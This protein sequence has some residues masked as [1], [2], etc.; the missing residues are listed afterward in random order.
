MAIQPAFSS[1]DRQPLGELGPDAPPDV[2][3]RS[4]L[5]PASIGVRGNLAEDTVIAGAMDIAPGRNTVALFANPYTGG[6]EEMLYID[7]QATLRWAR[8]VDHATGPDD[9]GGWSTAAVADDVAEVA[10]A[11]HPNGSVW[12]FA[13]GAGAAAGSLATFVL[14]PP[15]A[16]DPDLDYRWEPRP[17]SYLRGLE[18]LSVQYCGDRPAT[19]FVFAHDPQALQLVWFSPTRPAD[20]ETVVPWHQGG[21]VDY[22]EADRGAPWVAGVD[23]PV[24][25]SSFGAAR[26]R[27]V[28][29]W[30]V[31]DHVLCLTTFDL[32]VSL[33]TRYQLGAGWDTVLGVCNTQLGAGAVVAGGG[34]QVAIAAPYGDGSP[35]ATVELD[36]ALD[37]LT[38]WQDAD[39]LVHVYGRDGAATLCAVHQT[40]W[41]DISTPPVVGLVAPT[42]DA[43]AD[44]GGALVATTR[45]LVPSVATFAVDAYPDTLPSQHAMLQGVDAGEACAIY[46][47]DTRTS[48]WA[49][50]KVRLVPDSLPAPYLVRR[51]LTTLTVTN[52]YGAPA[53]G[54]EV[55][56]SADAPVDLEVNGRFYRTGAVAPVRL[57]SDA[58][59]AITLRVVATGLAMPQLYATV[60]GMSQSATVQVAA[61]VHKFLAGN[62][63]LPNHPEGFTADVVQN[64]VKPDGTPLF[65]GLNRGD[66]AATWP[67]SAADVVAWCQGAFAAEAGAPLPAALTARLGPGEQVHG[68]V[69]QTGDASQ[70]GLRVFT[71]AEEI[72]A[73][74]AALAGSGGFLNDLEDWVGDVWQGIRQGVIAVVSAEI[75]TTARMIVLGIKLGEGVVE[76]LHATWD[77]AVSAAHAVE[78]VFVAIGA[79][80]QEAIAWL[81]WAFDFKDALL[82]A[83]AL[84]TAMSGAPYVVTP[85]IEAFSEIAHDFF[86]QK[87]AEVDALFDTLQQTLGQRSFNA[88]RSPAGSVPSDLQPTARVSS[89]ADQ[90]QGP[91]ANWLMDKMGGGH[92]AARLDA[93][94]EPTGPLADAAG[95]LIDELF[96][97]LSSAGAFEELMAAIDDVGQLF[98]NL[99]DARDAESAIAAEISTVLDLG[100][101]LVLAVLTFLDD[102]VGQ[103]LDWAARALPEALK[104]LDAPLD[105]VPFLSMIWDFIL[106]QAGESA[107]DYPFTLGMVG[108][109][110]AA[111]PATLV[112]KATTGEAPFPDAELPFRLE[113]VEGLRDLEPT[114]ALLFFQAFQGLVQTIDAG[115]D[116]AFNLESASA[117]EIEVSQTVSRGFAVAHFVA[118]V[119]GDYPAFWGYPAI[120]HENRQDP[121]V[122]LPYTR[123]AFTFL[124]NMVDLFLSY[125]WGWLQARAGSTASPT[126]KFVTKVD[127][128][129]FGWFRIGVQLYE[130]SEKEDPTWYDQ[131]NLW[132][133]LTAYIQTATGFVRDI[134]DTFRTP[135]TEVALAVKTLVDVLGDIFSGISTVIQPLHEVTHPPRI[136]PRGSVIELPEG[137]VG[138]EYASSEF[139][140]ADGWAPYD[141]SL[142]PH[143]GGPVPEGL[144]VTATSIVN[145]VEKRVVVSGI[146][147][148]PGRFTFALH[149]E[150]NYGPALTD[151]V[152]VALTIVEPAG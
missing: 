123:Y 118:Y 79:K 150:D 137:T 148:Q 112:F 64:A 142:L 36:R 143:D 7:E 46:T 97:V 8:H 13:I 127:T 6:L 33:R 5:A 41:H 135:P 152:V 144:G 82:T 92:G 24:E 71:S 21:A 37:D 107:D 60:P 55:S 62:A 44:A 131:W 113:D 43:H 42:W 136:S 3:A 66:A 110:F 10:I 100:R 31:V 45:P 87:E 94:V 9:L 133:N 130:Y 96:E 23:S 93:F 102:V 32:D 81:A 19:P 22:D 57:T 80:I 129:V 34:T 49:A 86:L 54:V 85:T 105:G 65:P 63:T 69:L 89:A 147:K 38:S 40:G 61:D 11:V 126:A 101:H 56:L 151:T 115:L 67:P 114:K 27:R 50:E 15:A 108:A 53:A 149:V 117:G 139:E 39:G 14:T 88:L 119:V 26:V 17:V 73:R 28:Q 140:A 51:Y 84:R 74:D 145:G 59:G 111:Y 98:A 18:G 103:A 20:P 52:A 121:T 128:A 16:D 124:F 12:A 1:R 146:P 68:F 83:K 125:R 70:P 104:I 35:V 138:H 77:D 29:F 95:D 48:F 99:F 106:E 122:V 75:R 120:D 72:A 4:Q 2:A 134:N 47:Q 109:L 78:A 90:M 30:T 25:V 76:Y 132:I 116:L 141:W 58:A 91:H